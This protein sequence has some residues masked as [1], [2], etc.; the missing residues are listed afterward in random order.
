MELNPCSGKLP[1]GLDKVARIGPEA[2][3]VESNDHVSRL[4]GETGEPFDLFPAR[5]GILAGVGIA[6]AENHGIPAA[7][8]HKR[9]QRLYP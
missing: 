2:G 6:P 9:A 4:S 8:P 3:M 7:L 5:G 1:V